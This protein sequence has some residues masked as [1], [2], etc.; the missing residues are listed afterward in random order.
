VQLQDR[1]LA[2]FTA[3]RKARDA[4]LDTPKLLYPSIQLNLAAG[5]MPAPEVADQRFLK[6]PI[7]V[8]P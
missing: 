5:Q 3:F 6:L 7:R 1:D 2:A 4:K 8:R